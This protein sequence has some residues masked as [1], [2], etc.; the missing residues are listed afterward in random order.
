[1]P[2]RRDPRLYIE[3]ILEAIA[4]I[5]ADTG[6][7]DFERFAA[8]R[9]VRQ[10]VER[11]IEIL[12]EAS[13]RIPT[14]LKAAEPDIPWREIAGIGNVLRHDYGGVRP[15]ILWGIRTNRLAAL[16]SAVERIRE[17]LER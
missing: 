2:T 11:N 9:R 14:S 10:L 4:H 12:S 5:E 8:D 15:E 6:G 17:R 1:M 3:D 16:K 7:L 13:R